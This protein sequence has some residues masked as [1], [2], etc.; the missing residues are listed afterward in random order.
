[1]LIAGIVNM[2]I[3]IFII[4]ADILVI[5]TLLVIQ[6]KYLKNNSKF[7]NSF[8]AVYLIKISSFLLYLKYLNWVEFS[9]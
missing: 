2:I 9:T 7:K 5:S 4:I 3:N 1:M 8:F 6:F